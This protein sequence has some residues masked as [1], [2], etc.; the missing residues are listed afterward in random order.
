MRKELFASQMMKIRKSIIRVNK[1]NNI[2]KTMKYTNTFKTTTAQT[3]IKRFIKQYKVNNYFLI[4]KK[5]KQKFK[6]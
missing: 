6:I 1:T 2:K 4:S 3:I 5:D